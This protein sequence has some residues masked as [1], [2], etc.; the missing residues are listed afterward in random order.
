MRLQESLGCIAELPRPD[1]FDRFQRSIEP[2]WIEEALLATGTATVRKRRLP[3]EYV[4]WLV[5]GGDPPW[6][7]GQYPPRETASA[8]LPYSGSS[9][10]AR[11]SGLTRPLDATAGGDWPSMVSM[12]PPCGC[13][14]RKRIATASE[15][16]QRHWLLPAKSNTKWRAL[17][18][19]CSPLSSTQ[20]SIQPMSLSPSTTSAGR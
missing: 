19:H 1:D 3:A 11:T 14:T 8:S 5:I 9:P 20:R 10:A 13:R 16:H 15:E 17:D 7:R 2:S 12:A 18:G 6:L 4:L